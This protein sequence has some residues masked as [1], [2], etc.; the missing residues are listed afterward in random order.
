[1]IVVANMDRILNHTIRLRNVAEL[2]ALTSDVINRILSDVSSS[3][4]V[5]NFGDA[6][7]QKKN[8]ARQYVNRRERT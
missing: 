3:N 8:K 4:Y 2:L 7:F 5:Y 6:T 1:M